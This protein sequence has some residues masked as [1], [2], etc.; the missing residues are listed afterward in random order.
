[1]SEEY[2]E[3]SVIFAKV[4]V[5]RAADVARELEIAAMPTFKLF[6][7]GGEVGCTRGW[8]ED[9]VRRLLARGG[10]QR[11][12]RPQCGSEEDGERARLNP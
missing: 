5:D 9:A 6:G 12:N 10:A 4:D 11:E 1:M 3:E 2:T 8:S 7:P